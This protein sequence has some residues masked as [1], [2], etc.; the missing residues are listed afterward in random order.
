M[1]EQ[2]IQ[3]ENDNIYDC[4]P[5]YYEIYSR[6]KRYKKSETA[7]AFEIMKSLA[8][9]NNKT[10]TIDFQATGFNILE[11][12][13]GRGDH[14]PL[15]PPLEPFKIGKY[16]NLDIRDHT[17]PDFVQGDA[18]TYKAPPQL[19][20]NLIIG[21]FFT[22]S[23]ITDE[24]GVHSRKVLLDLFKNAKANLPKGGGFAIDFSP[25]GYQT[26]MECVEPA[27]TH[28]QADVEEGAELRALC[29]VPDG[30]P[31]VLSYMRRVEYDRN[32]STVYDYFPYPFEIWAGGEKYAEIRI[33]T[34]LTQRY[35]SE[36]ELVDIAHEAGFDE[37][38][39]FNFSH[40]K[41]P[42]IKLPMRYTITSKLVDADHLMA[43]NMLC[44][45]K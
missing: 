42:Y 15:Y 27:D 22:A 33:K 28:Y 34:P 41:G 14:Q 5:L 7:G 43:T 36:P 18:T 32:T 20:I 4:Y 19:N 45:N 11:I 6:S 39:L 3:I 38:Q 30:V 26:S 10:G 44:I 31:C 2:I 13:A 37:I 35:I 29:K 17:S 40:S 1:P 9:W 8:E 21:F 12:L 25:G 24:N 23:T 16:L